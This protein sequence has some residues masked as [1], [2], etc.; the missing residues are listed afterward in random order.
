MRFSTI[1]LKYLSEV[2]LFH[3]IYVKFKKYFISFFQQDQ[4]KTN[5]E[6]NSKMNGNNKKEAF[7]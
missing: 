3:Q 4:A 7:S 2:I 1:I 6:W 5:S